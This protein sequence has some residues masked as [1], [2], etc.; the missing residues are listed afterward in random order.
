MPPYSKP[1]EALASLKGQPFIVRQST[2]GRGQPIDILPPDGGKE[3]T[4]SK[5]N[6][7]L[8]DKAIPNERLILRPVIGGKVSTKRI[9]LDLSYNEESANAEVG[10]AVGPNGG[11]VMVSPVVHVQEKLIDAWLTIHQDGRQDLQEARETI[12]EQ[13]ETIHRLELENAELKRQ[14]ERA[15]DNDSLSVVANKVVVELAKG[16]GGAMLLHKLL[17]GGDASRVLA[18][19]VKGAT[20]TN[21]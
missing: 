4:E 1:S 5:F 6:Q 10:A 21:G 15:G 9:S 11:E 14:L 2:G 20:G 13:A 8:A 19:A 18:E 3:W 12:A 7:A 16:P 17:G